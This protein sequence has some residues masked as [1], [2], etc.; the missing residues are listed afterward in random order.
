M[1][2][3]YAFDHYHIKSNMA[4]RLLRKS[5]HQK[6]SL[7]LDWCESLDVHA[8][9]QI[10]KWQDQS[11]CIH[12]GMSILV[13]WSVRHTKTQFD[14]HCLHQPV[15]TGVILPRNQGESVSYIH[16]GTRAKHIVNTA[17]LKD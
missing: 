2:P 14:A 16:W 12:H 8:V 4:K 17:L 15:I 9:H 3:R 6:S 7:L 1:K 11:Y 5:K 13:R 10:A